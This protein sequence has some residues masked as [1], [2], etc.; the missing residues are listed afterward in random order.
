MTFNDLSKTYHAEYERQERLARLEE[1]LGVT[2]VV[3]SYHDERR[4][5]IRCL[6]SSGI[7][8]VLSYEN[9]LITAYAATVK[10]ASFMYRSV[11]KSQI[12]PKIYKKIQKNMERFPE[13][14]RY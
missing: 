2:R 9:V 11:G 14:F 12:S 4:K 7:V 8:M 3:I 10:E 5:N 1:L 13:F 6:T